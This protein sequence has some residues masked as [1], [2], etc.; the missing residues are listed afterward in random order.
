MKFRIVRIELKDDKNVLIYLKSIERTAEVLPKADLSNPASL[1]EF[2]MQMG[3]AVSKKLEE[4]TTFDA[5]ITLEFEQYEILDL[6]V[7]DIVEIDIKHAE[8]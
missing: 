7:G 5:F 8:R 3:M 4:L 1:L 6:K 2:S